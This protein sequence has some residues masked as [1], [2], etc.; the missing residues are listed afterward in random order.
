MHMDTGVFPAQSWFNPCAKRLMKLS[1]HWAIQFLVCHG[2]WRKSYYGMW[3]LPSTDWQTLRRQT[4]FCMAVGISIFFRAYQTKL[5]AE[6][7][8]PAPLEYWSSRSS[9]SQA[10]NKQDSEL[11]VSPVSIVVS[12]TLSA[13]RTWP[14]GSKTQNFASRFI[15]KSFICESSAASNILAWT[16][17]AFLFSSLSCLSLFRICFIAN[18]T[19][20]AL[21]IHNMQESIK[22]W[23]PVDMEH[24]C[25]RQISLSRKRKVRLCNW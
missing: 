16:N 2:N 8:L 17:A 22:A 3:F 13:S 21:I 1:S 10:S 18:S 11:S 24:T 12:R 4:I 6:R 14:S 19:S 5:R 20:N 25:S 23:A 7:H 9:T 15:R